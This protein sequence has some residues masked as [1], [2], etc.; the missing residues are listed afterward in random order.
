MNLHVG[1]FFTGATGAT[2]L[3]VVAT[4]FV[5]LVFLVVDFL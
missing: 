5:V 4:F 3:V 2:F 1:F